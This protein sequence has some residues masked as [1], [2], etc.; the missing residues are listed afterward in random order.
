MDQKL[1]DRLIFYKLLTAV[2]LEIWPTKMD[3]DQPNVDIGRKMVNC[4]F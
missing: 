4:Y 2:K 1:V 3:F